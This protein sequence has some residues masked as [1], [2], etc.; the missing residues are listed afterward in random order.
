MFI[1]SLDCVE[2]QILYSNQENGNM[3]VGCS[4]IQYEPPE[5]W[6]FDMCRLG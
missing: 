3:P 5:I 2:V 1:I 6:H 4:D